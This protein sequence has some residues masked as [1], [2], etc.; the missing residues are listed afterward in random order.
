VELSLTTGV[1]RPWQPDDA[2]SLAHHADDRRIWRNLRDRFPHPYTRADAEAFIAMARAMS[3][4]TFFAIAIDGNAVGGIG[5]TLHDDV[6]RV[7]AEIGYW[8]GAAFWRR[9]VMTSAL[10]ALTS[11]AFDRHAELRRIYA[12]PYAW[13]DA[14][15]RVL[16]K[17]GYHLE[18]RMRQSAIKDGQVTDQLL[19]AILRDELSE[20]G[21]SRA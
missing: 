2:S 13:S 5:Y 12:V 14:S 20:R 1:V 15:I 8:L 18:G 9:G 17:T 6:E 10:A 16:E 11:F 4:V 7:S 21:S 19:Y 3:P